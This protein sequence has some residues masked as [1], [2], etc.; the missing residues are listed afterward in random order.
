LPCNLV[1]CGLGSNRSTWLGPPSMKTQ[2]TLFAVAC[3]PGGGAL[4]R[5]S[6]SRRADR[7]KRPRP[8]PARARKSRRG[9]LSWLA[10]CA[11]RGLGRQAG[12]SEGGNISAF[13]RGRRQGATFSA[14]KEKLASGRP[15][16]AKLKG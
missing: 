6:S 3:R 13:Y 9:D 11:R 5:D 15:T 8:L 1:S 4:P 10:G 14:K 12:S 2:M 16:A 7:A